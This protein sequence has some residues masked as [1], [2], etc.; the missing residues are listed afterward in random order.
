MAKRITGVTVEIGGDTTAL[1]T[2]IK[3]LNKEINASQSELKEVEKLLKMDPT[4]TELL[5]Q[6]QR[7]LGEEIE[8]TREKLE[9]LKSI[10]GQMTEQLNSGK[11]SQDKYDAFQREI[12]ETEDRLKDLKKRRI[13]FRPPCNL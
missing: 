10:E 11:I 13:R 7:Y 5:T 12:M 4:S 2:A 6:K 9:T 8:A 3:N 1:S